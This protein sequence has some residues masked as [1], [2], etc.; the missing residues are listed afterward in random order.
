M[1]M[2]KVKII[3]LIIFILFIAAFVYFHS[4]GIILLNFDKKKVIDSLAETLKKYYIIEEDANTMAAQIE[5]NFVTGK[6]RFVFTPEQFWK[7]IINDLR[8]V[9]KD[10]HLLFVSSPDMVEYAKN[11]IANIDIENEKDRKASEEDN[12]GIREVRIIIE[13]IGHLDL[14]RFANPIYGKET[15]TQTMETLENASS[16]IIDLRNNNGGF[17]EMVQVLFSY[18]VN[19]KDSVLIMSEYYRYNN[20][21]KEF[22]SLDNIPG[23]RLDN[24]KVYILTSDFTFSAAE[25]FAYSMKHHDKAIVIGEQTRGGA[26]SVDWKIICKHYVLRVPISK[27]IHPVTGKDWEGTGVI[28]NISVP[29][30][31]ALERALS[32]IKGLKQKE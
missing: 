3:L 12:H 25:S 2:K 29:A 10:K 14:T 15:L 22:W 11:R 17:M 8:T 7:V 16:I 4:I 18:F 6:Y 1:I 30:N 23:K 21:T 9:C 31:Q 13:D 27:G 5:K 19:E 26:H 28:P 32:L 20:E 24:A